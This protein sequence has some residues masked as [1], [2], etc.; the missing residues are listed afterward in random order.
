MSRL[1][2][3]ALLASSAAGLTVLACSPSLGP[4][5]PGRPPTPTS[6]TPIAGTPIASSPSP[7]VIPASGPVHGY[8]AVAPKILRTGQTEAMTVALF[9]GQQPAAGSVSAVLSKSGQTV[10]SGNGQVSGRG[11]LNV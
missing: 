7:T 1:S 10:A 9:H 4:P 5:G 11:I 2:R 6:G 3:R 8:F